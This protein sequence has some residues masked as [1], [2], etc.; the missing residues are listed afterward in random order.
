MQGNVA[1]GKT[2]EEG[3]EIG[4]I[5]RWDVTKDDTQRMRAEKDQTEL[6]R[7]GRTR[8]NQTSAPPRRRKGSRGTY[9]LSFSLSL[10]ALSKKGNRRPVIMIRRK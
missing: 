4:E 7:T 9:F 2:K 10:G 1:N 6:R 5:Y 3:G 8:Q